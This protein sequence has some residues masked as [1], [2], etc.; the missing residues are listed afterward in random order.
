M[1]LGNVTYEMREDGDGV[2]VGPT[3]VLK[4]LSELLKVKY[5]L[6]IYTYTCILL[7]FVLKPIVNKVCVFVCAHMCLCVYLLR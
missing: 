3:D 6:Y 4:T 1:Y 5:M 7:V 2:T